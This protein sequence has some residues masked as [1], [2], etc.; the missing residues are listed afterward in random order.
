MYWS[1]LVCRWVDQN[2]C[3]SPAVVDKYFQVAKL[4]EKNVEGC[5]I[6]EGKGTDADKRD[7]EVSY[8]KIKKLGHET[9][10]V[11]VEDGI[12]ELLKII[13]HLSEADLKIMKNV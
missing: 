8:A 3:Y 5:S 4:I 2:I 1:T 6:T 7:Y 13:P 9:V 10:T 11:T 12:K